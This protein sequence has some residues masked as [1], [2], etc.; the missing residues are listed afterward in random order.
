MEYVTAYG[1]TYELE[2][3]E[4]YS[5]LHYCIVVMSMHVY[6][7]VYIDDPSSSSSWVGWVSYTADWYVY[8][9]RYN[10]IMGC[11]RALHGAYILE[12]HLSY[13]NMIRVVLHMN[14]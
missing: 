10:F 2:N 13:L 14:N 7:L 1:L 6:S 9:H 5:N 3:A 12:F 8:I 11:V 4:F